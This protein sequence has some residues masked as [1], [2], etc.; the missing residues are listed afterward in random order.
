MAALRRNG[1]E[2]RRYLTTLPQLHQLRWFAKL[3]SAAK[4]ATIAD[5]R[6]ARR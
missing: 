5:E 4:D 6:L 3:K 1:A 2:L